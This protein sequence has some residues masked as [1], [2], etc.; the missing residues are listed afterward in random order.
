MK[1]LFTAV[2][3][4]TTLVSCSGKK[5]VDTANAVATK[6]NVLTVSGANLKDKGK[7]FDVDFG[8]VNEAEKTII[9]M[10]ADIQ[11]FRGT[12]QGIP[13]HAFFGAGERTIDI[14]P[15]S[16]KQL[17]LVCKLGEK[18]DSGDYKLV[19]SRVFE[20]PN[21][22][23]RTTGKELAKNIEWKLAATEKK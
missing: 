23:R 9:V 7:K 10:L 8:L 21:N 17:H 19:V 16:K 2:V 22:D 3:A 6:S 5:V 18:V 15:K 12:V 11:C 13:Q 14:S 1:K 20:N 4:L